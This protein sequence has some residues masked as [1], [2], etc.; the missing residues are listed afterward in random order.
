M[1]NELPELTDEER[2]AMDSMDMTG[3]L[4]APEERCISAECFA[5]RM[6]RERNELRARLAEV[7][8][9]LRDASEMLSVIMER[10]DGELSGSAWG[11]VDNVRLDLLVAAEA[12]LEGKQ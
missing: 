4:G 3:I 7:E 11:D 12:A 2:T 6:F 10:R 9:A 1:S 8:A 5:L